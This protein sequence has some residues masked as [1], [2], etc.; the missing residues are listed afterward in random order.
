[1]KSLH[2]TK[3]RSQLFDVLDEVAT[4]REPVE[5]VRFKRP[6]AVIVP[7]VEKTMPT[8]LRTVDLLAIKE[9]CKRHGLRSFSL[10]GSVLRGDFGPTSD[11]DVLVDPGD[12]R[13]DFHA[14]CRLVDELEDMFG[15]P[16]DM[17]TPDCLA[18]TNPTRRM[19]IMSELVKVYDYAS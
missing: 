9:F 3:L 4:T 7:A 6:V 2:A 5:V 15:R 14:E 10:F 13:L 8:S 12:F 17:L 19:A 16:V 18:R 11:V 1:M